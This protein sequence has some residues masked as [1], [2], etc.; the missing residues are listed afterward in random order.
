MLEQAGKAAAGEIYVVGLGPGDP[1]QLPPLNLSLMQAGRKVYLRTRCHPVVPFLEKEGVK[2]L[3]LDD[4]YEKARSFEE[5]YRKMADF[6]IKTAREN[7]TPVVFGVPGHPLVGETVVRHLLEAGPRE[8][9]R[10]RTFSAPSFLEVVCEV[11]GLDPA[12]GLL[13]VDAFE[14]C[15][16][17][18]A[19]SP[20]S[21][22]GGTGV[23]VVQV[24]NQVLASEV[25]LTLM[26]HFPDDHPVT[27]V[28][29]AGVRGEER[30]K[31]IPLY[32]LDRE[33]ELDHLTTLYLPP[34]DPKDEPAPR[35]ILDPLVEVMN[36]LLGPGGC[37]WDRQQTHETLKNY[38]IEEAYEVID[39]IE[40]GNTHKLCEELGDLLLQ[41][42]FH[43]ALAAREQKFTIN[44]VI[45]GIT[46]KLKR[47]HP[48]VFGAREVES[49]AEVLVNWEAIKQEERGRGA[50]A[51]ARSL[52][53][54]I[55]RHLPALQRAQKVQGKAALVGFDW[56]DARGAA[57]KLEEEWEEF[58]AA[59]ARGDRE[60]LQAE[61]G[62]FFFAA[63]NVARLLQVNAE[64]ALRL[65]VDRF[66]R[67]FQYMEERARAQGLKLQDLSL[68]EL[69]ALW[70]E[71]KARGH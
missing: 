21:V 37:P 55:P 2:L 59:W 14:L 9:V 52:L 69:D 68:L 3:P 42:V 47:R 4:F 26:E 10:V 41:V 25:K 48:H 13:I 17:S 5:V 12:E 20:F 28:R 24:Y 7:D 22:P 27:L 23:L 31:E 33:Q 44:Q 15:R 61:V 65:A 67:R 45:A 35:Y 56:P 8:K 38:L 64:E 60:A 16:F 62:D 39:A 29:A 46:E 66:V 70:D 6:L 18:P 49:A 71:A 43:A 11:L 53:G 32:Q 63:V 50:G 54:E 30:I 34:F 58:R 19:A 36:R 40:E 51:G 57:A 1:M